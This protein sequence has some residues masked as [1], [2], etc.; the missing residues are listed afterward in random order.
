[1]KKIVL[2]ASTRPEMIKIAPL[3]IELKKRPGIEAIRVQVEILGI[4]G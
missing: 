4:F 2:C 1:M 3:Y